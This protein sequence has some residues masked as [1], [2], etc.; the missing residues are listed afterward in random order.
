MVSTPVKLSVWGCP[1]PQLNKVVLYEKTM[2]TKP[3][4]RGPS[5]HAISCS[6]G[7]SMNL[8]QGSKTSLQKRET[9][10]ISLLRAVF[11]IPLGGNII[12]DDYPSNRDWTYSR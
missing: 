8:S 11:P 5:C 10:P 12:A 1:A 2:K 7:P 4:S 6:L 9:V 3:F